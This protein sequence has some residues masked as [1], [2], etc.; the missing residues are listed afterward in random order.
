MLTYRGQGYL[1][2]HPSASS[3]SSSSSS[4]CFGSS[5]PVY[6]HS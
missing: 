3:S 6:V 5:V 4:F 2:K 1:G